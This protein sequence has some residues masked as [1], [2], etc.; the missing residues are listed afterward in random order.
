MF[1]SLLFIGVALF[2]SCKAGAP[3]EADSKDCGTTAKVKG[4]KVVRRGVF[5]NAFDQFSLN[6]PE[7]RNDCHAHYKFYFR[8][9]SL[10]KRLYEKE[11]MPPLKDLH[12]SFGPADEY[13][14]FP[15]NPPEWKHDATIHDE[16]FLGGQS[17]KGWWLVD[18]S[19]GNKNSKQPS[20]RYHVGAI[21]DSD[22]SVDEDSTEV[23]CEITYYPIQ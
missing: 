19:V 13:A 11:T 17:T 6:T 3:S 9:A 2:V 4:Y 10:Y 14:Y 7:A 8:W 12:D 5:N 21:I 23:W 18:F 22:N 1:R 16:V 15:H 20:T